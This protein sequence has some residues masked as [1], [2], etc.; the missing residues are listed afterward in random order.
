MNNISLIYASNN[1]GT[2]GI[3]TKECPEGTLPWTKQKGDMKYFMETTKGSIVIMGKNTWL[4][5]GK[6]LKGRFNIIVSSTLTVANYD[7]VIIVKSPEEALKMAL[8]ITENSIIYK[9]IY[10]I[11]GKSIYEWAIKKVNTVHHTVIH[12][13]DVFGIIWSPKKELS[14]RFEC[15]ILQTFPADASNEYPYTISKWSRKE[16]L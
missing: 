5:I 4:S 14:E 8:E 13:D 16:S 1:N 10:F 15:E 9:G 2:I 12:Q 6:P 3:I 7:D 11:G